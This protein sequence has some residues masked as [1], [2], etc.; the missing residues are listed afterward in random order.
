MKILVTGSSGHL[1]EAIIR[2]LIKAKTAYL[3]IDIKASQFTTHIGSIIDKTFVSSL[4]KEVDYI[5]HTATL[6]KPHVATHTK[7]DFVDTNITGTL[8]LLEESIKHGVKGMVYTSTTST[9]GDVLTPAP[10]TPAIWITEDIKPIPKNIYGVSKNAAEDLCQLFFRNHGLSCIVLK[11]SRFFPEVDDKK[12]IRDNYEDLN[13]KAIEYLY[14]RVDIEDAALAH[15]LAIERMDKIG[16]G[17]YIISATSPFDKKD[18][19]D[20]NTDAHKVVNRLFPEYEKL[21]SARGWKML[22]RIDRVYVNEKAR[23]EL[24]WNPK[25]DFSYI[26]D[27]LRENIDFRSPLALS[28]GIKGYHNTAFE[29]GPYPVLE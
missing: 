1:G 14:R 28:V 21:F 6:H 17:K 26:L 12:K 11:T 16:F 24:G 10:N 15:L 8:N 9:F 22:P 3:G 4:V 13:I 20:L 27:C 5:V 18:L 25:Y 23:K 19:V 29:E 7:Q 2:Q